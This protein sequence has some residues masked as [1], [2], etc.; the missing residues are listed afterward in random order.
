MKERSQEWRRKK[1]GEGGGEEEELSLITSLEL[2]TRRLYLGA[3]AVKLTQQ[4]GEEPLLPSPNPPRTP[5]W[6]ERRGERVE[7]CEVSAE[8]FSLFLRKLVT[9]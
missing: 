3:T 7:I 2:L 9:L 1:G 4:P 5:P 6:P 8:F